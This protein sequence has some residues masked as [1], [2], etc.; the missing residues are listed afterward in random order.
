MQ[1]Q[2]HEALFKLFTL[3][4]FES[5]NTYKRPPKVN[6]ERTEALLAELGSPEKSLRIVHVAGSKGKGSVCAMIESVLRK[7]GLST[8]LY[9]SPS[10]HKYTERIS[11]NGVPIEEHQ[12][13]NAFA[14]A[15]KA[16]QKIKRSALG[17]PT[18]F[19]VLTAMALL[20]FKQRKVDVVVLET[21][22][23]GRLDSTNA[24]TPILTVITRICLD[25]TAILGDSLRQIAYEKAGIIKKGIPLVL[26]EQPKEVE[27]VIL[28]MAA[29][30]SAEVVRANIAT[31]QLGDPRKFE[32]GQHL[33]IGASGREYEFDLP[34]MGTHQIDNVRTAIAAVSRME[35]CEASVANVERGLE[36]IKWEGRVQLVA[37]RP[38]RVIA[39]GAH[40]PVSADALCKTIKEHFPNAGKAV[41][42]FGSTTGHDNV[43]TAL[44]LTPI[45]RAFVVTKSRHPRSV[46]LQQQAEDLK[47]AGVPVAESAPCTASAIAAA[48]MLAQPD[49]LI[50]GCGSLFIA[51]EVIQSLKGVKPELYPMIKNRGVPR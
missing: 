4:D 5:G 49:D 51:A 16:A 25:H 40:E 14:P 38:R 9:S 44:A 45:A 29:R 34:L 33:H 27:D 50:V 18:V 23:G 1:L 46:D 7:S 2:Y 20:H 48:E 30:K 31:R 41:F 36:N 3:F 11:I 37:S 6:L 42:V 13:V 47:A 35:W 21:G 19:E 17:A 32:G 8:G 12:F 10:L 26:A 28:A 39:D 24:V 22:M 43:A 15:W